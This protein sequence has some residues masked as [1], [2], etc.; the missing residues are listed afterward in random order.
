[1]Y[2]GWLSGRTFKGRHHH[3]QL[4]PDPMYMLKQIPKNHLVISV[5]LTLI[6]LAYF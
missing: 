3:S 6:C 2:M 4:V 1:M 5:I